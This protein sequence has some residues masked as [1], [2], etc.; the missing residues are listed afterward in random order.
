MAQREESHAP[1]LAITIG[2]RDVARSITSRAVRAPPRTAVPLAT[3]DVA[4]VAAAL[5]AR[6][7]RAHHA[8][9]AVHMLHHRVLVVDACERGRVA[10]EPWHSRRGDTHQ[11]PSTRAAQ[12]QQKKR[13]ALSLPIHLRHGLR[14]RRPAAPRVEFVVPTKEHRAA[15]RAAV[16]P[17]VKHRLCVAGRAVAELPKLRLAN[18]QLGI[19]RAWPRKS[20]QC[21]PNGLVPARSVPFCRST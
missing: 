17:G 21:S 7:L 6:H 4:Q 12:W 19:E 14:V 18:E 16:V 1:A 20:A 11:A 5:G 9:R 13:P 15:A 10:R 2:P 8:V 3:E